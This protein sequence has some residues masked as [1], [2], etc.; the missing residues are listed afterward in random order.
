MLPGEGSET[1][2]YGVV[3]HEGNA[4]SVTTTVNAAYGSGIM[5]EGAGFLLNN[6]MDDFT[7]LPG[8]PNYYNLVQGE[9]NA[10]EPF[11]RPLSS[12]TPLLVLSPDH[13]VV[14]DGE[15]LYLVLGSPGGPRIITSVLQV[16]L[17]V[18][19]Y[20]MEIQEAVN[21]PRLHHQWLP[22]TVYVERSG[23]AMEALNGLRA[24]GQNVT[25]RKGS[26]GC[27]HAIL[28]DSTGWLFG[29][30]DPR[31]VGC[32]RGSPIRE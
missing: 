20:G 5:V 8:V 17:N 6:E 2:H 1:T 14:G 26:I 19:T 3:D 4:V 29:A 11:K 9:A 10:I 32:A 15:R 23:W 30:P 16:L 13:D 21:A 27:V 22:D 31:R 28:A 7:A 24:W 25:Y 18:V 12:M